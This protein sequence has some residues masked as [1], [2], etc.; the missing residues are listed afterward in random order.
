MWGA[1]HQMGNCHDSTG[2]GQA[3]REHQMQ[4]GKLEEDPEPP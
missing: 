4:S 3:P 2:K 1:Q